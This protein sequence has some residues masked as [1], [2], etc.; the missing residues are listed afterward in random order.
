MVIAS[1]D[2]R[3]QR[4]MSLYTREL[5]RRGAVATGLDAADPVLCKALAYRIVQALTLQWKRKRLG[6]EG[7]RKGVRVWTLNAPAP[8]RPMPDRL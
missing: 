5:T 6:S 2:H 7:I 4:R 8:T 3:P 1:D